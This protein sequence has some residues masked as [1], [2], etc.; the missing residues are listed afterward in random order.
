MFSASRAGRGIQV[1][2]P[3]SLASEHKQKLR[4]SVTIRMSSYYDGLFP[5]HM[6]NQSFASGGSC[7]AEKKSLVYSALDP[8]VFFEPLWLPEVG[9]W[10]EEF[11]GGPRKG[12]TPQNQ[13]QR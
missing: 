6:E 13:T 8:A 12:S 5:R 3:I 2:P 1:H 9:T 10:D 4:A 11:C 7:E